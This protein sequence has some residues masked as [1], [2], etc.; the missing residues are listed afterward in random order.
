MIVTLALAC[1]AAP[2]AELPGDAR[3]AER[4]LA[5]VTAYE[6]RRFDDARREFESLASEGAAQAEFM[7]G[8]MHEY[9]DGVD[10]SYSD[11]VRW[12]E[13]AAARGL[14]SAETRLGTLYLDGTGVAPDPR[15]ARQWLERA[16]R[17]RDPLALITLGDLS[18]RGQGVPQS[19]EDAYAYYLL[20]KA[21][22]SEK[23]DAAIADLDETLSTGRRAEA[24]R[25]A[26]AIEGTLLAP[27]TGDVSSTADAA[28]SRRSATE[29]RLRL[30]PVS[31][32]DDGLGGTALHLL[33]PRG[34]TVN[35]GIVWRADSAS[36]ADLDLRVESADASLGYRALPR[37]AYVWRSR[38]GDDKTRPF[39][40]PRGYDSEPPVGDAVVYVERKVLP[41]HHR[42][43]SYHVLDRRPLPSLARVI[44]NG[45]E[46]RGSTDV[47]AARVRVRVLADG[48]KFDEDVYCVLVQ[49]RTPAGG[50]ELVF[51]GPE[52]LYS[53]RAP[54]GRLDEHYGILQSIAAS[55]RFDDGWTGRYSM[56]RADIRDRPGR[57][58]IS[59]REFAL[60]L[61]SAR[62]SHANAHSAVAVAQ[63]QLRARVNSVL[64]AELGETETFFDPRSEREV[65]L[66]RGF[67][68]AWA[69]S[70][71]DYL[72]VRDSAY[73]PRV[74][75][76]AEG[77]AE[78]HAVSAR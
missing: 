40:G 41:D 65:S 35:G 49:T 8:V 11:A 55:M 14:T 22:G 2:A 67:A 73:D 69:S 23:A 31:V 30:S 52:R 78:L 51:W 20:A 18:A 44:A 63:E 60:F 3:L 9:G 10:A 27:T 46:D 5:A 6:A 64:A 17:K 75:A 74:D 45:V 25:R 70:R 37:R 47:S 66:P 28:A 21:T 71:G 43:G 19:L 59:D 50:E 16:A 15:R 4:Y 26:A 13:A 24:A 42:P 72:G 57:S 29:E 58:R 1:S 7:L 56:L 53:F 62:D 61:Q 34:W 68:R 32:R 12:Y 48:R 36:P 38:G 33:L 77:W 54:E 39:I 76:P